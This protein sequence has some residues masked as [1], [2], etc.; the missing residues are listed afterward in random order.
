MRKLRHKERSDWIQSQRVGYLSV[1]GGLVTKSRRTPA[2]PWTVACQAPLTMGFSGR[3]YWSG[4]PF[5]SPGDLPNP[6][7]EPGSP[8][9]QAD[10]SPAEPPEMPTCQLIPHKNRTEGDFTIPISLKS[11]QSIERFSAPMPPSKEAAARTF[12][13]VSRSL[14]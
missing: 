12:P 10:S 6:G 2:T 1:G 8:A 9:L 5:P 11:T 4:L 13:C 14:A 7:V 3:E